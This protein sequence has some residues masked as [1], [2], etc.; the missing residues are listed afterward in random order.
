MDVPARCLPWRGKQSFDRVLSRRRT[1]PAPRKTLS[2]LQRIDR[3]QVDAIAPSGV[4]TEPGTPGSGRARK[5]PLASSRRYPSGW[6]GRRCTQ[7]NAPCGVRERGGVGAYKDTCRPARPQ[8]LEPPGGDDAEALRSGCKLDDICADRSLR[9]WTGRKAPQVRALRL[10]QAVYSNAQQC[11]VMGGRRD[12]W[13]GTGK[14]A[15]RTSWNAGP[16]CR[17][18]ALCPDRLTGRRARNSQPDACLDRAKAGREHA[19]A[20]TY[21]TLQYGKGP[22]SVRRSFPQIDS[23]HNRHYRP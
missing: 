8:G 9:R 17:R 10:A 19:S 4:G 2:T 3:C 6:L 5:G 16:E 13:F 11:V 1:I 12:A 23:K 14:P 22:H 15:G 18:R 21:Q 20:L 7:P